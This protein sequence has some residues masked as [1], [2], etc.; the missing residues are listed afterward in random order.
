MKLPERLSKTLTKKQLSFLQ[1]FFLN[2]PED[3]LSCV[4]PKV[5]PGNHALVMADD[6]CSYVYIL[7]K[8][9]LQAVE[10]HVADEPDHFTEIEAPEIVGDFELFTS[11]SSRMITLTTLE[12]SQCLII[13][14]NQYLAWIKRDANALFIRTRMVIRQLS[15]QAIADRQN[16]FFD[17]RTR[18]LHFL[19]NQCEHQ[20]TPHFPLRLACTRPEIAGRLGCSVRTVNRVVENLCEEGLLHLERGKLLLHEEQYLQLKRELNR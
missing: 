19:Y 7:L 14:A 17:N 15:S 3:F 1:D 2:A 12:K 10:E 11:S 6:T 4:I 8:G 13:P 5:Y 16:F 18:L 20:T 9:R